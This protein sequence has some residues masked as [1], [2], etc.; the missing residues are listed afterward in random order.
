MDG[1]ECRSCVPQ[2]CRRA[3]Q[4]TERADHRPDELEG[5][6]E[7]LGVGAEAAARREEVLGELDQRI[8]RDRKACCVVRV[9]RVAWCVVRGACCVLRVA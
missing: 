8:R 4:L 1:R 5:G 6:A 9:L 2:L 7:Q 3:C